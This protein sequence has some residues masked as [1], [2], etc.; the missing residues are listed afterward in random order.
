MPTINLY[1]SEKE[2]MPDSDMAKLAQ[3]A[4]GKTLK[5]ELHD[6]DDD[7][8]KPKSGL[9][10]HGKLMQWI[11]PMG[12]SGAGYK[13]LEKKGKVDGKVGAYGN[14]D[15]FV[16]V[17]RVRHK[18]ALTVEG[19]PKADDTPVDVD[20]ANSK[21]KSACSDKKVAA[22]IQSIAKAGPSETGHGP[23]EYLEGALHAHVTNTIGVAWFW[24]SGKMRIV[25]VGKKNNQIK[26]KQRGGK[27]PQLKTSEY[28]WYEG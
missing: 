4:K 28:D 8:G 2:T 24:R 17:N 6:R 19:P 18:N 10:W 5:L 1:L 15:L 13:L 16:T 7:K 21:I 22:K 20:Y 14:Y 12:L 9:D 26:T 3:K 27:G 23:V 11:K 25:A